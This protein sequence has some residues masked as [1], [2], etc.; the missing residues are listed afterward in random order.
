MNWPPMV[1]VV[2]VL[3]DGTVTRERMNVLAACAEAMCGAQNGLT[4]WSL[5]IIGESIEWCR[6]A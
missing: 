6:S 2:R 3:H 5:R 4:V 1:L